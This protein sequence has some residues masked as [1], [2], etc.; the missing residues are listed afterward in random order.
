VTG[1][2]RG[3]VLAVL[4]V[5]LVLTGCT[6]I[7]THG[8][9]NA[10][11][12][13]DPGAVNPIGLFPARPTQDA[14]PEEIVNGFLAAATGQ[15]DSYGV[16]RLFLA[17][18]LA[19]RWKPLARVLV[20]DGGTRIKETAGNPASVSA[21][22]PVIGRL[23]A[24]GAYTA[25]AGGTSS[26]A[27]R[28]HLTK[29]KGQWRID[30]AADGIVLGQ[31]VFDRLFEDVVTLRFFDPTFRRLYPD[32]RRYLTRSDTGL[33]TAKD[34]VDALLAGPAA[35][36]GSGVTASP[37]PG[38]ARRAGLSLVGPV[39][40]VDIAVPGDTPST[41]TQ[42]RM[43]AELALSLKGV[44]AI[45]QVRL[46]IN[47]VPRTVT[48][49]ETVPWPPPNPQP[50]GL[51]N[52]SF[53]VLEGSR[54][55]SDVLDRGVA[56]L[57]PSAA[58]VSTSQGLAAVGTVAGVS[59]V[60]RSGNRTNARLVDRRADLVDPALDPQGWVYS[61]PRAQPDGLIAYDKAGHARPVATSF[62][63][64]AMVQAIEVSRDG[65]RLLVL[66]GMD[67]ASHALVAGIVRDDQGRP[68][69]LTTAVY[70]VAVGAGTPVD[71]TWVD[72]GSVAT[73]TH[74]QDGDQVTV[75][76]L[77]GE[78][79]SLGRPTGATD[80]VGSTSRTDLTIRTEN[81]ALSTAPHG[82]VWVATGA[83]ADVLAVQ[84]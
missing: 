63:P 75:Q 80:I 43:L 74:D 18:T 42:Q 71:A 57:N 51:R 61:V 56:A 73:V 82:S 2:R 3:A 84:R 41:V 15:Q 81:G 6:S 1:G 39:A 29:V 17:P 8:A 72:V 50:L 14:S 31:P 35:P 36:L 5:L 23:D 24:H 20:T 27:L 49:A 19:K 54:V 21:A 48:P 32:L 53:G 65:S 67:G 62:P 60:A 76:Q 9:V 79:S 25:A 58:T 52:R 38:G 30:R 28:F 68:V 13:Q 22:V 11:T 83:T 78:S 10:G 33:A 4:A 77:G 64:A 70:Q 34:V 16:A 69:R 55:V 37:F 46:S 7:P 59:V 47:G 40:T 12:V 44:G 45:S 66:L 26:A